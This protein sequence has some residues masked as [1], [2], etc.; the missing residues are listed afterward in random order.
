MDKKYIFI[1]SHVTKPAINIVADDERDALMK[2]YLYFG[3]DGKLTTS[4]FNILCG[5]S[6]IERACQIFEYLTDQKII[7][8]AEENDN[9]KS[10]FKYG[11]SDI[12]INKL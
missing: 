1:S 7:Y 8:F 2:A 3:K 10:R 11:A 12:R 5:H 4:E 6:T 9:D